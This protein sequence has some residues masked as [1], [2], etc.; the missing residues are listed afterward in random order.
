MLVAIRSSFFDE[1][2]RGGHVMRTQTQRHILGHS[3]VHFTRDANR[4]ELF[5][6]PLLHSDVSSSGR[7][8]LADWKIRRNVIFAVFQTTGRKPKQFIVMLQM[9][10]TCTAGVLNTVSSD[11]V[12]FITY[13]SSRLPVN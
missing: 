2:V 5:Q 9:P 13:T 3:R 6:N 1:S 10:H 8:E 11:V 7:D 4:V 12:E